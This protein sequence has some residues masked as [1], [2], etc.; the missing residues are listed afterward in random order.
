M[1][2]CARDCLWLNLTKPQVKERVQFGRSVTELYMRCCAM[3]RIII[4]TSYLLAILLILY[5]NLN[6][7]LPGERNATEAVDLHR[8]CVNVRSGG[9]ADIRE[10]SDSS[11]PLNVPWLR[12]SRSSRRRH[13][14]DSSGK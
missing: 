14:H 4:I 3:Y 2:S 6:E 12:R 8:R 9:N 5:F 7:L 10:E 1:Q 13:Q 11:D